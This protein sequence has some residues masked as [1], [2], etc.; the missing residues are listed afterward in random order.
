[1][2]HDWTVAEARALFTKPLPDLVF[3]AQQTLRAHFDPN[4]I[5]TSQ[6][7][8]VKTGGCAENCGYCA[9]SASFETGVAATKLM[10]RHPV[11]DAAIEARNGG[12]SR[13][14]M[15][16]A[17][18]DLKD[19]DVPK[20]AALIRE[21][22]A[23]GLETCA[24]LGMLTDGQAEAL[25]EAGLDYYNHNLDTGRDYY[26]KV[27]TTRTY[28]DRL[29]TLEKARAAG[30]K[31]CCGGIVGMGESL[32]DRLALLVELAAM[33]P[34]PESVP[35]NRL[36]PIPGTPL[37]D[38]KPVEEI[39]IVRL[40]AC[41]RIML[42]TSYVRL[43]AGRESMSREMQALCLIA[44]ANSFFAGAKLLTTPNQGEDEDAAMLRSFGMTV[45]RR[46]V[47]QSEIAA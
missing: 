23:L 14:C 25:A 16:A 9:Q 24:T 19:R 38:S 28:D 8:S 11:V 15:G 5:Q 1:M 40:I 27:V 42:P 17:W 33:A 3:E 34:H 13:F 44:G 22:K 12:A 26:R 2:R 47:A 46:A 20:V 18:R 45:E 4:V 39:D 21:V 32:D 31:L 29:D 35:I 36:I 37:Q 43:S 30:L 7:L 6:L 41:A 10:D